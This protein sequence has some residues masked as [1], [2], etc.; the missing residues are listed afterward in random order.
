MSSE[1]KFDYIDDNHEEFLTPYDF[2]R[3]ELPGK[4]EL[5]W[6]NGHQM[7]DCERFTYISDTI[8]TDTTKKSHYNKT[9]VIEKSDIEQIT[10]EEILETNNSARVN[11][12]DGSELVGKTPTGFDCYK[13]DDLEDIYGK[14][15]KEP[16]LLEQTPK[17]DQYFLIKG[18]KI[19]GQ[20]KKTKKY[21][22]GY[23][24]G[25]AIVKRVKDEKGKVIVK[26]GLKKYEALTTVKY[27]FWSRNNGDEKVDL[28]F[29]PGDTFYAPK[30]CEDKDKRKENL[31]KEK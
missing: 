4:D 22:G 8:T 13:N 14:K 2:G 28:F 5:E 15:S 27:F 3:G 29:E 19:E 30:G 16:T 6:I 24:Y 31:K 20:S 9:K 7:G 10:F 26:K 11:L 1:K 18:T 17:M 25:E 12:L 23:C 21:R